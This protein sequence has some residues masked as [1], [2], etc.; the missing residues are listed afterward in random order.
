MRNHGCQNPY[1]QSFWAS[2][3]I[4]KTYY[5][6]LKPPNSCDRTFPLRNWNWGAIALHPLRIYFLAFAL[7][8]KPIISSKLTPSF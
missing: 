3:S 2:Q 6:F 4:P 5:I 8:I 7:L 1:K